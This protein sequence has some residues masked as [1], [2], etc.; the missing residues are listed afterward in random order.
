MSSPTP[1]PSPLPSPDPL[2]REVVLSIAASLFGQPVWKQIEDDA[3]CETFPA[4][5][6]LL[7]INFAASFVERRLPLWVRYDKTAHDYLIDAVVHQVDNTTWL[8]LDRNPNHLFQTAVAYFFLVYGTPGLETVSAHETVS[9]PRNGLG[10]SKR[11]E[12]VSR[13]TAASS[14][15]PPG[16]I[17][18]SPQ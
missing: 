3:L 6:T 2:L 1:P 7:V 18:P 14:L 16:L 10:P 12:T 5:E 11:S 17:P 8:W 15:P 9:G 13:A 4:E